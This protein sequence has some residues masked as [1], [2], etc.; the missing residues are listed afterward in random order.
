MDFELEALREIEAE[1]K[2]YRAELMAE[3]ERNAKR[4]HDQVVTIEH[5]IEA[6]GQA[7]R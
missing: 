4:D 1:V 5:V 6:K 7:S 3:A 2:R